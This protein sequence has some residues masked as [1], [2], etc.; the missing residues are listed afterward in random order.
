MQGKAQS[1]MYQRTLRDW[2]KHQQQLQVDYS[3]LMA[4]VEYLSEEVRLRPHHLPLLIL[5]VCRSHSRNASELHNYAFYSLSSS[6]WASHG[7]LAE[8]RGQ[9][10]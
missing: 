7:V 4:R 3:E 9:Y 5:A 1:Q 8:M 10:S 6:S 2:E